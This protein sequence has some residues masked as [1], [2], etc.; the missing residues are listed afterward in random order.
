MSINGQPSATPTPAGTPSGPVPTP[1]AVTAMHNPQAGSAGQSSV[2]DFLP[3]NGTENGT[4][5]TGTGTKGSNSANG[6][7]S[8]SG[9][10][11]DKVTA[12]KAEGIKPASAVGLIVSV[13][14]VVIAIALWFVSKTAALVIGLIAGALILIGLAVRWA[15][16]RKQN[17]KKTQQKKGSRSANSNSRPSSNSR[18][19]GSNRRSWWPW[20]NRGGRGGPGG[21]NGGSRRNPFRNADGSRR[22]PFSRNRNRNGGSPGGQGR[23]A[24]NGRPASQG[25]APSG[26]G[27]S[28]GRRSLLDKLFGRNKSGGS[29][30]GSGSG[31]RG[32][33]SAGGGGRAPGN[34]GSSPRSN[35]SKSRRSWWPFGGGSGSGSGSGGGGGRRNNGGSGNHRG[36]SRRPWSSSS[37]HGRNR[38]WYKPWS[39]WGGGNKKNKTNKPSSPGSGGQNGPTTP[40][41]SAGQKKHRFRNQWNKWTANGAKQGRGRHWWN[42]NHNHGQ[43]SGS[44]SP[45]GN[46]AGFTANG[47]PGGSYGNTQGNS[48]QSPPI[49]TK[50]YRPDRNPDDSP[51]HGPALGASTQTYSANRSN[52]N[53]TQG[54]MLSVTPFNKGGNTM[55]GNG[56]QDAATGR[57]D[58]GAHIA[59]AAHTNRSAVNHLVVAQRHRNIARVYLNT[60]DSNL[61]AAA[62]VHL[63]QA[64]RAEI[65]AMDRAALT[66]KEAA[67]A[68]N[69]SHGGPTGE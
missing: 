20:G 45:G 10:D 48:G 29:G 37:N 9:T 63:R 2:F 24:G 60:N 40:N 43:T 35:G 59:A 52:T 50:S 61:H 58:A 8:K 41:L 25:R 19:S 17:Q 56:I 47:M 51:I 5:G 44:S 31:R 46:Y 68:A 6:S 62:G 4:N 23:P 15:I 13:L 14:L 28:Q 67:A 11:K 34:R 12:L 26:N 32:G 64:A 38:G 69:A 18:Q 57:P 39:W 65:V 54:S 7:N 16:K 49:F 66:A 55:S 27:G 33:N 3:V 1:A 21:G 30:G 22:N 53:Q 36:G 42:R